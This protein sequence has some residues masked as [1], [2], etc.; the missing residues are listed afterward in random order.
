MHLLKFSQIVCSRLCHD[1]I[2]PAGA[3]SSGLELLE[4]D[5]TANTEL[6][7]L[8]KRSSFNLNYRLI[9]YRATFGASDSVGVQTPAGLLKIIKDFAQTY[10]VIIKSPS[11]E[12]GSVLT[13]GQEY[14]QKWAKVILCA[15]GLIK[16]ITPQGGTLT[17]VVTKADPFPSTQIIF[18]GRLFPPKEEIVT[19]LSSEFDEDM[20]NTKTVHALLFRLYAQELGASLSLTVLDAKKVGLK[21]TKPNNP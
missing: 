16:D 11:I 18:E 3:V 19:L 8:I 15:V 6:V 21:I 9:F 12:D 1:L 17:L 7:D 10:H 20:I 4:S 13:M 2:S 14:F 5:S